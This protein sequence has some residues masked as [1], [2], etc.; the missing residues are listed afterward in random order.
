[1]LFLK[2]TL[3][4]YIDQKA[5][6]DLF[7]VITLN[8]NFA[9]P[10]PRSIPEEESLERALQVFWDKGFDRT[11]I[12]DLSEALG[13]GPSSIYNAFGSKDSLYQRAIGHYME[14]HAGFV[15]AIFEE[16][17]TTPTEVGIAQLLRALAKI[18]SAEETPQGCALFQSGGAGTPQNSEACAFTCGVKAKVESAILDLFETRL[19][20]G[21]ELAAS[22]RILSKFIIGTMRGLSQ[23]ACDGTNANDLLEVADHAAQSCVRN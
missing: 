17:A 9:M 12:T 22:P 2:R 20:A 18:Y 16:A 10:R 6:Q 8:C 21:D 4:K 11:S 1:V 7:E 5:G 3:Q 13:V 15:S 23:L 14:T 19:K